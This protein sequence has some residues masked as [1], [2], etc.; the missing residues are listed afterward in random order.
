MSPI[1]ENDQATSYETLS[2]F[3]VIDSDVSL[4]SQ[5]NRSAANLFRYVEPVW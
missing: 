5:P 2:L 4:K 3:G 1:L